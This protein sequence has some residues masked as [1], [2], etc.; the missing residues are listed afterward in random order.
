M[1]QVG[2]KTAFD[3][4]KPESMVFVI[5]IDENDRPSGMIAGWSMKCSYKP[6]MYAVALWEEGYT[7]KL[8]QKSKEF[9]VAVPN[10][11]LIKE[12][13]YFGSRH[14]D[15]LDK[16]KNTAIKTSKAKYIK[17]P[18]I[19]DATINMECKLAETTRTGDHF[20]FFGEI[21]ASYVNDEK[22]VLLNMGKEAGKR[23]FSEF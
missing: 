17:S 21:L 16:F 2:I 18:L 10:K 12:L 3:K 7:H 6:P 19:I 9:V 15:K 23:I 5:S 22:K 13:E 11:S 14:G 20:V 8:V 1:K 4:F